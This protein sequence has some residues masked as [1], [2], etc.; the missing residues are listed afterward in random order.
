MVVGKIKV[1]YRG[2]LINKFVGLK[3]KMRS[4]LSDDGKE[5]NTAKKV[6]TATQFNEFRE[7][8]FKKKLWDIKWKESKV[9]NT[10]LEHTKS[11]EYNYC[12]LMIKDLF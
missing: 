2:V 1:G 5:Y 12:V 6:N 7:T 8:L 3:S 11:T 10:N 9:K 4:M